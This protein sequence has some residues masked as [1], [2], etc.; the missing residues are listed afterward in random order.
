MKIKFRSTEYIE[1]EK[2]EKQKVFKELVVNYPEFCI[3]RNLKKYDCVEWALEV[4]FKERDTPATIPDGT[5]N[6][7]KDNQTNGATERERAT[8]RTHC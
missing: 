4:G 8:A 3:G 2:L 7:R 1:F 5:Q 6:M